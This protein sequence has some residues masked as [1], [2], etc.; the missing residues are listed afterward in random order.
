MHVSFI[1]WAIGSS[2]AVDWDARIVPASWLSPWDLHGKHQEATN[3]GIIMER[4]LE[5]W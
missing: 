5:Q 1:Q 4:P 2:S 3:D